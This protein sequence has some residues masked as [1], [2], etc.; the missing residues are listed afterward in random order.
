MLHILFSAVP[1]FYYSPWHMSHSSVHLKKEDGQ[2]LLW[3]D[4]SLLS[5][6]CVI[7][8]GQI[9]FFNYMTLLHGI[10]LSKFQALIWDKSEGIKTA[11]GEIKGTKRELEQ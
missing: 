6:I 7:N 2:L 8:V 1:T 3:G 4:R 10:F 11:K 9:F 5:L